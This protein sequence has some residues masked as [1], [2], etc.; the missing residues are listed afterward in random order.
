M[1]SWPG[2]PWLGI[3]HGHWVTVTPERDLPAAQIPAQPDD[4]L[5]I[6]HKRNIAQSP[7]R[8]LS[9]CCITLLFEA[10]TH[11]Q[12]CQNDMRDSEAHWRRYAGTWKWSSEE[13]KN[14]YRIESV[15]N[16]LHWALKNAKKAKIS[17]ASKVCITPVLHR[18]QIDLAENDKLLATLSTCKWSIARITADG[19]AAVL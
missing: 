5:S 17:V 4:S 9:I 8:T 11:G 16:E 3:V 19:R 15:D 6:T 13:C 14:H 2:L 12:H 1:L 10:E 7:S 18:L